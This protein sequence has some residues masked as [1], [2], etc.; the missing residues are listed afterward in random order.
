MKPGPSCAGG[1]TWA[2]PSGCSRRSRTG[3]SGKLRAS[4]PTTETTMLF[5]PA[6]PTA[7][8]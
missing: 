8:R 1:M 2:V 7:L 3:A 5:V 6:S 4:H